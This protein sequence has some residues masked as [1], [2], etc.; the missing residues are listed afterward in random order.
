M[1]KVDY[2]NQ[3]KQDYLGAEISINNQIICLIG[4]GDDLD[5]FIEFFHDY[6]LIETHDLKVSFDSLLSVLMD[7]RKE[8]N[9]IITNINNP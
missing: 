3:G 4:I 9:E 7:C 5:I 6:R 2:I 8:L 1:L